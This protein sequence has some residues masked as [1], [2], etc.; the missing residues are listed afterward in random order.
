MARLPL[1]PPAGR[2]FCLPLSG[3]T[4][5]ATRATDRDRQRDGGET[6]EMTRLR[7][8]GRRQDGRTVG[9]GRRDGET[10]GVVRQIRW[11]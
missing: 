11:L 1:R 2:Y 6:D 4:S 10:N 3:G 7:D 5:A 9:R 8:G